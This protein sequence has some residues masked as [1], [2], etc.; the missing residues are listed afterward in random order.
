MV[1]FYKKNMLGVDMV[2]DWLSDKVYYSKNH[3]KEQL[4][5]YVS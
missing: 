5:I 3:Q 4:Y 2:T 1:N